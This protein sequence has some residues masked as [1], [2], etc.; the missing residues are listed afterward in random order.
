MIPT[1]LRSALAPALLVGLAPSAADELKLAPEEGSTVVRTVR[2]AAEMELAEVTI[3]SEGETRSPDT[4][5]GFS[6]EQTIEV[7]D[8]YGATSDGQLQSLERTFVGLEYGGEGSGP[9]GT[10]EFEEFSDLLERV[11]RFSWD[12]DE[13]DYLVA[14]VDEGAEDDELLEE[15]DVDMDAAFL[16]PDEEVEVGDS[17][18]IPPAWASRLF[19]LGGDLSFEDPEDEGD[20]E[21]PFNEM[22]DDAIEELDGVFTATLEEEFEDDDGGRFARIALLLDVS[23]AAERQIEDEAEGDVPITATL[24]M[25]AQMVFELEGEMIW[26]LGAN[27]LA[28]LGMDGDSSIENRQN[29]VLEFPDAEL[30]QTVTMLF[31]G[32]FEMSCEVEAR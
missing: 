21:D 22:L 31:E 18:E 3:E 27:R 16:L 25:S 12:E 9:E 20:E 2:Y 28:S 6:F 23:G 7:S 24:D 8:T 13:E 1:S 4:E 10:E 32:T 5:S 14:F 26:D 17:W 30:E 11:V 29:A 19:D 15:L